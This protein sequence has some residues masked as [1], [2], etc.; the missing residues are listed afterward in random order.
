MSE[1]KL[2]LFIFRRD[3]RLYDNLCLYEL[4]KKVDYILPIFI[5]DKN[6]IKKNEDNKYYH[7]NNVVQFMC[8]SLIDLNDELIKLKSKLWLFYGNYEKIIKDLLKILLD[9]YNSNNLI[10]G[11]NNDFSNY[12]IKRDNYIKDIC[13]KNKIK[14]ITNKD[15]LTLIDI[16]EIVNNKGSYYKQ[17]GA[18]YKKAILVDVKKPLSIKIK[19]LSDKTKLLTKYN[20]NINKLDEFYK[21]NEKLAQNGGRSLA[22]NKLKN[23][24]DFKDYNTNRDFLDYNTTNLSA[25]LN[26]GCISIRELYNELIKKLGNKTILIKQLYW[27]DFFLQVFK[28]EKKAKEYD[29]HMYDDYDNIKW[30][31][32]KLMEEE[33]ELLMKSQT[34]FLIVDAAMNEMIIT[35]FMHNRARML[36]GMFWT[37]YLLINPFNLEYGSQTGFSRM[38]VDAIGSTQNKM[39][40]HWITEL[41]YPGKKYS[42]KGVP[43][44]GRP[45]NINNDQIKKFDNECKYIKKWLPHLKEIPNKDIY[46]WNEDISKKYNNIHSSPIFDAKERYEEWINICK[47]NK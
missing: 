3:L 15:D 21:F 36:V 6:Q 4:S 5:L 31:N 38:L 29:S 9:H 41:D 12:A 22:L 16:D 18:Y 34:G 11:F 23:L 1:I 33:W 24:K 19:Y 46:K 13:D 26:L 28:N 2:G 10:V 25:Y 44:S 17:Y 42:S 14:Y 40:H 47:I 7:S 37:K 32:N 39:N 43:L 30:R 8:E 20:F 35:G 45:M 27:R